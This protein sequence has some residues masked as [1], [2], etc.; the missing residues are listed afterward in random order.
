MVRIV[1]VDPKSKSTWRCR[2]VC[3]VFVKKQIFAAFS[4][5]DFFF[6]FTT[7]CQHVCF[8]NP[9]SI[10][11][12]KLRVAIDSLLFS[13]MSC[14]IVM[15]IEFIPPCGYR[16]WWRQHPWRLSPVGW[17]IVLVVALSG[18]PSS[19]RLRPLSSSYPSSGTTPL[20]SGW[21]CPGHN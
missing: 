15:G 16:R 21:S 17:P 19:E 9:F 3:I 6:F 20:R 11:P 1:G 12:A 14:M 8:S 4:L 5:P 18:T 7:P 13:R 10:A 2:L